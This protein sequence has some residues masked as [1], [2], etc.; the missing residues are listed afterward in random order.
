VCV[1]TGKCGQTFNMAQY[2]NANH[3]CKDY[4]PNDKN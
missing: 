1:I 4:E 3:D 2:K